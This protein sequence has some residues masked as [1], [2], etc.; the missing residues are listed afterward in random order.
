MS[1]LAVITSISRR[2]M[3]QIRSRLIYLFIMLIL[4]L[5]S[6][7]LFI[8]M[9]SQGVSRDLPVVVV[10]NDMSAL[11][12]QLVRMIDSNASLKVIAKPVTLQEGNYLMQKGEAYACILIPKDFEHDV[13]RMRAPKVY[14]Y[15]NNQN[16]PIGGIMNKEI[17]TVVRSLSAGIN[18]STRLKKGE[19]AASARVSLQPVEVQSHVL[20]N[21]YN[22]YFYYLAGSLLPNMLHIFILLSTIYCFG[23]ELKDKTAAEL[24]KLS[25][26]SYLNVLIGKLLPYT[27]VYALLGLF[28]NTLLFKYFAVPMKGSYLFISLATILF[29]LAYQSMGIV[30]ITIAANVRLGLMAASFYASTAYTFIG[31]TFPIISFP[32]PAKLWAEMLPLTHFM[33]IYLNESITG[34]P[35]AY[36]FPSVIALMVFIFLPWVLS[37]RFKKIMTVE[38]FWGGQ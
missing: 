1:R 38:S 9:F 7:G 3:H 19:P 34:A 10:D 26:Q 28:M 13:L 11:S 17:Y 4:P 30:F 37:F 25:K 24:W 20:F 27:A 14:N 2:E 8:A 22:N 12:R 18:Y 35:H 5:L 31:M 21:P 6:F 16:L 15:Y 29:V 23:I 36:S 32:L 33:R